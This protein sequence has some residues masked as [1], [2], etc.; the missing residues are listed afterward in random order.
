MPA[1]LNA[2]LVCTRTVTR[3]VG[4]ESET[5]TETL[6]E[7]SR[8]LPVTG[9]TFGQE[10]LG[11]PIEFAIP[12]G[13]RATTA[14]N[15]KS[16]IAWKV[17]VDSPDDPRLKLE[18]EVPV[19]RTA[20]SPEPPAERQLEPVVAAALERDEP[21]PDSRIV[22]ERLISG[23][24]V[25]TIA[26]FPG[27]RSWLM[28]T[29]MGLVFLAIGVVTAYLAYR[30]TCFLY[31][32]TVVF[33]GVGLLLCVM[34]LGAFGTDRIMLTA[35]GLVR[36]RRRLGREST[37]LVPASEVTAVHYRQ[38]GSVGSTAFHSITLTRSTGRKLKIASMVKGLEATVWLAAQV[39][40]H[41]GLGDP[42]YDPPLREVSK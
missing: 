6:W 7:Q 34:S 13:C 32:F 3:N 16:P 5:K 41:L 20:E 2:K 18:F 39:S 15:D 8:E 31:L 23:E 27:L 11:L 38:S 1:A 28:M 37:T 9:V 4:G 40:R 29:I 12:A 25:F 26:R 10:Q 24:R 19:F 33:G 17:H 22:E 36:S 42:V 35:D 30:Q 21:P 14:A